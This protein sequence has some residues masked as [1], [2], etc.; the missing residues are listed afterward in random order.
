MDDSILVLYSTLHLNKSLVQYGHGV[1][2]T[3][4][5]VLAIAKKDQAGAE[6]AIAAGADV[7]GSVISRRTPAKYLVAAAFSSQISCCVQIIA[8]AFSAVCVHGLRSPGSRTLPH[9]DRAAWTFRNQSFRQSAKESTLSG[10]DNNASR[11]WPLALQ[12]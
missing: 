10:I 1:G 8:Q 11:I 5:L 4:S 6:I 9:I 2:P 12:G 3:D 7:S